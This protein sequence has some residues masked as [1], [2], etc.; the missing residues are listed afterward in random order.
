MQTLE[1]A[2]IAETLRAAGVVF[3]AISALSAHLHIL[4]GRERSDDVLRSMGRERKY[5]LAGVALVAIGYVMG[6]YSLL[7]G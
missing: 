6:I 1:T 4:K 7:N 3:I 2:I 5:A